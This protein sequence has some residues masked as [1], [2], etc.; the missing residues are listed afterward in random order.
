MFTQIVVY[1]VAGK[2]AKA[3]QKKQKAKAEANKKN[4]KKKGRR[5]FP[6]SSGL[7]HRPF[8]AVTRV[9]ISLGTP[10]AKLR[11]KRNHELKQWVIG[12]R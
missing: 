11:R 9:R 4:K 2:K 7:G 1:W 10:P 3:K 6:S 5:L 12:L 8:T